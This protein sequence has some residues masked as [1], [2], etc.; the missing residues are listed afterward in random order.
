MLRKKVSE[1][2]PKL[3]YEAEA[4][5]LSA[6]AEE[7]RGAHPLSLLEPSTPQPSR[8]L[9]AP[10]ARPA[11]PELLARSRVYPDMI[12]LD[13]HTV[14]KHTEAFKLR[15]RYPNAPLGSL[16]QDQVTEANLISHTH[17]SIISR[18]HLNANLHLISFR[19][20]KASPN[21]T[22][23]TTLPCCICAAPA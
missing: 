12:E 16:L 15:A 7:A 6:C 21:C 5:R 2:R 13:S 14:A 20:G 9:P 1:R 23:A 4:S 10:P 3:T 22:Q 8:R 11:P 17:H 19:F 18:T